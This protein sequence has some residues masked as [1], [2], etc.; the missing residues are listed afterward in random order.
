MKN[1]LQKQ[2]LGLGELDQAA[3]GEGVSQAGVGVILALATLIG[4]WGIACLIGGMSSMGGIM[5]LGRGW[6]TA[7]TG[8]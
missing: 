2:G 6:L 3:I 1:T 7:V 5:E 8:M 4:L